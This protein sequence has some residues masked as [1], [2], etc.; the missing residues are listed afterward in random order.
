MSQATAT[1]NR[2]S[3]NIAGGADSGRERIRGEQATP[4]RHAA[5]KR[6]QELVNRLMAGDEEA[7][8]GLVD[9]YHGPMVRLALAF[10]SSRALAEEVVQETWL[11]VVR[12]I[13]RFEG[14]SS[15]KNW[16]FRILTNRAKTLGT[17]ESR[18]IPFTALGPDTRDEPAVDPSQFRSD[19]SWAVRPQ[20]W[21]RDTPERLL[22]GAQAK[23]LIDELIDELPSKQRAVIT[24]F[25]VEGLSGAEVSEMLGISAVY[26]RVLLHRARTRV[27][28]GL[29]QRLRQE[30]YLSS[31]PPVMALAPA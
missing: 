13:E 27:R 11:A 20:R 25:D 19:G 2:G 9:R 12:G 24:L 5:R 15:L 1:W 6:D 31:Q 18:S 7:F 17:R 8:A 28:S 22:M 30:T 3:T 29:E 26:Q 23:G 10:V 14:R 16:I 21:V 4:I